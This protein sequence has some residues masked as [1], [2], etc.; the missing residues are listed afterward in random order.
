MQ[1]RELTEIHQL[2]EV[3]KESIHAPDGV[4]IF[5]HSTRCAISHLAW[6]RFKRG[7]SKSKEDLPVYYLDLLKHRDISNKIAE[8]YGVKHQSPQILLLKAGDCIYNASHTAIS[9][10]GIEGILND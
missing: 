7:W 2:E 10:A 3:D 6:S 8:R 5:K 9:P 4:L 1:C